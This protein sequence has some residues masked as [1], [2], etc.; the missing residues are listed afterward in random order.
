MKN[1]REFSAS[2]LTLVSCEDNR[3]PLAA[4]ADRE[5]AV[6]PLNAWMSLRGLLPICLSL[7]LTHI[8]LAFGWGHW[9]LGTAFVELEGCA[10]SEFFALQIAVP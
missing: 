7:A 9:S 10:P 2:R 1:L 5:L 3:S 4:L 6:D 8:S